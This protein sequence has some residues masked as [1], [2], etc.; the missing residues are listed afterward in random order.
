VGGSTDGLHASVLAT[1]VIARGND[2]AV[3]VATYMLAVLH[4]G[5]LGAY[6]DAAVFDHFDAVNDLNFF[7]HDAFLSCPRIHL[8]F[9][10]TI[11]CASEFW[12]TFQMFVRLL[13]KVVAFKFGLENIASVF[14]TLAV[15]TTFKENDIYHNLVFATTDSIDL[16]VHIGDF[17]HLVE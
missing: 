8:G 12:Q 11:G 15:S 14:Q 13:D 17:T 3:E 4:Y 16:D 5:R 7:Q 6:L 1:V 10:L 9:G 2:M